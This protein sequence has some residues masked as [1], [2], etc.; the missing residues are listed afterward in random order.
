MY[1][2]KNTEDILNELHSGPNGL[3]SNDAEQRLAQNGKNKL[4]ETKKES[5]IHMFWRQLADPM[6]IILIVAAVV[7]AV[8]AVTQ[9]ESLADVIIIGIVVLLNAILG[10]YQE[11][12]VEEAIEALQKMTASAASPPC[13]STT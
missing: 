6:T 11:S 8:I 5:L 4:A 12:K 3:N 10:V 9:N 13:S 7:S 2:L 1:Y